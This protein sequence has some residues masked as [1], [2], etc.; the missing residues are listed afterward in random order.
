M[1]LGIKRSK[2]KVTRHAKQCRRVFCTFVIHL[3]SFNVKSCHNTTLQNIKQ[4]AKRYSSASFIQLIGGNS[5]SLHF[6]LLDWSGGLSEFWGGL[7]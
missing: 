3:Y 5:T 4:E 2:V 6:G 1:Y 7:E